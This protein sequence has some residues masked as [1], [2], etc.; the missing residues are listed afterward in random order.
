MPENAQWLLERYGLSEKAPGVGQPPARAH[1]S[2]VVAAEHGDVEGVK[3]HVLAGADANAAG[4]DG[5]T[6]LKL[7]AHL[8]DGEFIRF[9]L[10]NGAKA[11]GQVATGAT[12]L[13]I[14]IHQGHSQAVAL[15]LAGGADVNA[16]TETGWTPL[17]E[18]IRC[19]DPK[20][21]R[22]ILA[23]GAD[24]NVRDRAGRTVL[25]EV[26]VLEN[27]RGFKRPD[28]RGLLAEYGLRT[29][30][31]DDLGPCAAS[32]SVVCRRSS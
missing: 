6:A 12:P 20:I 27:R 9:L 31:S 2:L 18:A 32:E 21:V 11:D 25:M 1:A 23:E 10:E 17:L 24:V 3:R 13:M 28:I 8:G 14:A 7:G 5:W 19:G 26:D 29:P 15:L 16:V 22:R 30:V 4:A